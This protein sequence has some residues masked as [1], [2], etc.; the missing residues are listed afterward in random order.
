MHD[1]FATYQAAVKNL[2]VTP[3]S[4]TD[5]CIVELWAASKNLFNENTAIKQECNDLR[6]DNANMY[7][8]IDKLESKLAR[9]EGASLWKPADWMASMGGK[10]VDAV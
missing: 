8:K 3:N 10:K 1:H 2:K 4:P 5:R 7:D 6:K 9:T